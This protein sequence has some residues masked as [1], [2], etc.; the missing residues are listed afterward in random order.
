MHLSLHHTLANSLLLLPH[1]FNGIFHARVSEC[2][3]RSYLPFMVSTVAIT[4]VRQSDSMTLHVPQ[5]LIPH[6]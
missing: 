1:G 6:T 4:V 2:E 5:A 3:G